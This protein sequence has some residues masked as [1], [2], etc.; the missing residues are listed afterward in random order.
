MIEERKKNYFWN[1]NNR[2]VNIFSFI[3][4]KYFKKL[5]IIMIIIFVSKMCQKLKNTDFN[6]RVEWKLCYGLT[7]SRQV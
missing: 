7:A 2:L 1:E 3:I 4:Y 6:F 5:E